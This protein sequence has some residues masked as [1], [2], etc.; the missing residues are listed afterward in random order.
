MMIARLKDKLIP[1]I[2][3]VIVVI[4]FILGMVFRNSQFYWPS[5]DNPKVTPTP[6]ATPTAAPTTSVPS[7]A[8]TYASNI[9]EKTVRTVTQTVTVPKPA[10]AA[11]PTQ[12]VATKAHAP[13][14]TKANATH[15]PVRKNK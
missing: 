5:F 4:V 2:F 10:P 7:S 8:P 15:M 13:Q 9:P 11:Q 3:I 6:S 12:A 14:A 1:A